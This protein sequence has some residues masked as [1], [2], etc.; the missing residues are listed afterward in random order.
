MQ[1]KDDI[2]SCR[3]ILEQVPAGGGDPGLRS[4]L[5]RGPERGRTARAAEASGNLQ[6]ARD[7]SARL[8][9]LAADRDTER[10]ELAAANAFL[11]GH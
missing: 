6:A 11:K 9:A 4:G 2:V 8:Q 5:G 3:T 10:K 1:V 7:Y